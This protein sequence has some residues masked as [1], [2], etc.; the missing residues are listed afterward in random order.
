MSVVVTF[1][2]VWEG[3]GC[4][5]CEGRHNMLFVHELCKDTFALRQSKCRTYEAPVMFLLRGSKIALLIDSGDLE[6]DEELLQT[7]SKLG[8]GLSLVITHT[9]PHS[10]HIKGDRSIL[11][12]FPGAMLVEELGNGIELGERFVEVIEAGAGHR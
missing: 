8:K 10:D 9:H 5:V 3:F 1:P 7:L 6:Y 4:D 11:Q 2:V 12:S